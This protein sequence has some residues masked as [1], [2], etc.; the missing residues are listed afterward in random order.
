MV[1]IAQE[2][3][4]NKQIEQTWEPK[5]LLKQIPENLQRIIAEFDAEPYEKL[6]AHLRSQICLVPKGMT[7][8]VLH[9]DNDSNTKLIMHFNPYANNL[10]AN[11]LL[12]CELIRRMAAASG[13][14]DSAGKQLGIFVASAPHR[15]SKLQLSRPQH[16][17]VRSGDLA[18]V[19]RQYL[20][21]VQSLGYRRLDCIGYSQ[22]ASLAANAAHQAASSNLQVDSLVIGDPPNLL[23]RRGRELAWRY[24]REYRHLKEKTSTHPMRHVRRMHTEGSMLGWIGSAFGSAK[25][26]YSL[27]R[28]LSR[29][30]LAQ[31]LRSVA[32]TQVPIT[33]GYGTHSSITPHG[34]VSELAAQHRRGFDAAQHPLELIGIEE[35]R[36]TWGDDIDVLAV[37]YAYGLSRA[38]V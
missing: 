13:V 15:G 20:N 37:F 36:H 16:R 9:G 25:A 6:V 4:P 21:I 17:I 23:D 27:F 26:N 24:V 10:S 5:K 1:S 8:A 18:A 12:R 31:D 28:G 2:L 19:T 32:A 38:D 7:Y 11:M 33:L 14:T 34:S 29:N 35:G 22:G 30:Q 3:N